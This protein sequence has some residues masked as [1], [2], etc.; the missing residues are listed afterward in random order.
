[1]EKFHLYAGLS[2]G[3]GGA[4]YNQTIEA[5]D[6]DEACKFAYDLAVEKYQSYEGCH[7]IMN[8][9]DCYEDAVKSNFIDKETMRIAARK[10][11]NPL[12]FLQNS[13]SYH[14][15]KKIG[16]HIISGNTK[17]NVMDIIVVLI[18]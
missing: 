9:D 6:I 14:F 1:M 3:F 5:E 11:V 2:G 7:G 8:W 17:T 12:V 16:G 15:F 4:H 13:D 18:E 10:N